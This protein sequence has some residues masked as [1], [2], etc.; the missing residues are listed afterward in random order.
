MARTSGNNDLLYSV[1]KETSWCSE[2][3]QVLKKERL[4]FKNSS[5]TSHY[6]SLTLSFLTF[7]METITVRLAFT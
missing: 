7:K 1:F 5:W 4:W 3:P 2:K 6:I